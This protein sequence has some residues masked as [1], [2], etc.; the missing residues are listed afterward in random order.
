M[1]T[2][3]V[4]ARNVLKNLN[5]L[6]RHIVVKLMAWVDSVETSGLEATRRITGYH[7]ESLHGRREG[8]RSIR[9]SRSYRAIYVVK[10]DLT[11]EFVR[12]EEVNNHDY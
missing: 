6:P 5:R 2:T 10:N 3:V 8:Q 1:I 9:L 4:L 11:A 12:I 7:D